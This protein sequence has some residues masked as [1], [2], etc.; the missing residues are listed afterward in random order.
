MKKEILFGI[1]GVIVGVILTF[2]VIYNAAPGMMLLEDVSPF[3]FEETVAKFEHSVEANEWEIPHVYDLQKSMKKFGHD[4]KKVKVFELCHPDH[5]SKILKLNDE[6]I[7]STLMPCRIAIYT[8]DDGKTYISR[9]NSGMMAKPM[10]GAIAEV[11]S[12]AA[13]QNEDILKPIID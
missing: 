6:R 11:M 2:T 4:V 12:I 7:V 9:M 1:V 5:S 13:S 10:G 8:K 3:G